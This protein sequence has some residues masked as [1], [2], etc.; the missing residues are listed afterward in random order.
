MCVCVKGLGCDDA[1]V[2]G[3]EFGTVSQRRVHGLWLEGL[4]VFRTAAIVRGGFELCIDN[5]TE[6]VSNSPDLLN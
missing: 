6:L 2:M 5:L 1:R 3:V 4:W